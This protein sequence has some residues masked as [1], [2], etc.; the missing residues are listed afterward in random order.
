MKKAR[1]VGGSEKVK[2]VKIASAF[3]MGREERIS[4]KN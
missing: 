2:W 4:E 3:T 1:M